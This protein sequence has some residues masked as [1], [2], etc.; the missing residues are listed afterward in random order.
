[1]IFDSVATM[2]IFDVLVIAM[3]LLMFRY[4]SPDGFFQRW[5]RGRVIIALGVLTLSLFYAADLVAHARWSRAF[6]RGCARCRS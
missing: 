5:S 6:R 2:T 4:A 3:A 1:M